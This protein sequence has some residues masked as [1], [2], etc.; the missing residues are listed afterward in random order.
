MNLDDNVFA[1]PSLSLSAGT[2]YLTLGNAVAGG[3]GDA[4]WDINNGPSVAYATGCGGTCGPYS[5]QNVEGTGTNS[6]TFQIL[7]GVDSTSSAPEPA[8]VALF[9]SGIAMLGFG[10][11]RKSILRCG[12]TG[13]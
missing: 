10:V 7:T 8:S 13:K 6:N 1:V 4:Y 3:P 5:R 11:R 12:L 2:Y 9:G